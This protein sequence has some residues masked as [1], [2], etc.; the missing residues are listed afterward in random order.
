M[1][2][3][4]F[5]DLQVNGLRGIDFSG[6]DLTIE[7]VGEISRSLLARGVVAY[8]PTLITSSMEIY[9]RNLPIL[10]KACDAAEG[11][12]V[13]GIHLEGP[14]ISPEE[15]ARGV[16]PRR[17]V[18]EPSIALFDQLRDL[19][20]DRIAILTLAP[21]R[22]GAFPLI[23]HVLRESRITLA[24]GHHLAEG[25]TI[26]RCADLGVRACVHIGNGL[27]ELVHRHFNPLWPMLA[28]DRLTG[29]FVSDGFHLPKDML[30]VCLRAKGP[31][32]FAVT[33]DLSP[34]AGQPPGEYVFHGV[35]VILERNRH[36][37]C[38]GVHQL[39]GSASEMIDCMNVMASLE[40][41]EEGQLRQIGFDT[42]LG[43]LNIPHAAD[44][45]PPPPGLRFDGA[46]FSPAD[47]D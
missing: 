18:V 27:P 28:D 11:A 6:P 12:S 25:E 5:V 3:P 10:A 36:L 26:H 45:I 20:E 30:R 8:C 37:H 33:S 44:R 14:F 7:Q 9:R 23:E 21:E 47:S 15:G 34:V 22:P 32:R 46:R 24:M 39:A 2:F 38:R 13:L 40:E 31:Q 29:L 16:H 19:A 42:P 1:T 41:M 43:L 4:G 17:H 35:E